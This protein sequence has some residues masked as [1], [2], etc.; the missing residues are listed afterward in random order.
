MLLVVALFGVALQRS[1]HQPG[2]VVEIAAA[3][4][5]VQAQLQTELFA[6]GQRLFVL[7]RIISDTS[8]QVSRF[9]IVR[10]MGL[11][12]LILGIVIIASRT[13][14]FQGIRAVAVRHSAAGRS[15]AARFPGNQTFIL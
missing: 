14:S 10:L 9:T 13:T 12:S 6:R 4:A 7:A 5:D 8:L 15:D 11:G 1:P 3:V 2:I